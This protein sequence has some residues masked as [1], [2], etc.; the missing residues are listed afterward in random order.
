MGFY[1]NINV[2]TT[3]IHIQISKS[4]VG[5]L[6]TIQYTKV[7]R[8]IIGIIKYTPQNVRNILVTH[9]ERNALDIKFGKTY[10]L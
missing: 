10:Q 8:N 2:I 1:L 9:M 6:G 3:V 5:T 7:N 4:D